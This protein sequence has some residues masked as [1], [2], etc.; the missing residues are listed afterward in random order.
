MTLE[1]VE[2]GTNVKILGVSGGTELR[3]RLHGMC[4]VVGFDVEVVH[5]PGYGPIVVS[6]CHNTGKVVLG[7]GMGMKIK[8]EVLS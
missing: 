6:V 8:V 7:R 2:A 4:I 3:K 5:N 1:L